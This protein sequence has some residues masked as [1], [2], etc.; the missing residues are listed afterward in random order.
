MQRNQSMDLELRIL[1]RD[2]EI[3]DL[4][5]LGQAIPGQ[6]GQPVGMSGTVQDITE[7]K[8]IEDTLRE[9]EHMLRGIFETAAI[10]ISA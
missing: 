4:H 8:Q 2:G 5:L 1:V 10:G 9:K 6:P 3:R 7:R